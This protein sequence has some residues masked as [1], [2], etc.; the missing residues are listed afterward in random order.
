MKLKCFTFTP[1][2]PTLSGSGSFTSFGSS[3]DIRQSEAEGGGVL[4]LKA[5]Q[6]TRGER[7]SNPKQ[8]RR[9]AAAGNTHR[10]TPAAV[11]GQRG[12][13]SGTSGPEPQVRVIS[14]RS[15]V[16][17]VCAFFSWKRRISCGFE[18][19]MLICERIAA[20]LSSR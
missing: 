1:V 5:A 7:N 14:E 4:A 15:R 19:G 17:P 8:L 2:G 13:Q 12:A 20:V 16:L 9:R 11:A 10:H 3:P 6:L 18:G